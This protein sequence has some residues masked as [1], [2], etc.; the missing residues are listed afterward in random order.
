MARRGFSLKNSKL[1]TKLLVLV[2]HIIFQVLEMIRHKNG[3]LEHPT[4]GLYMIKVLE[5]SSKVQNRFLFKQYYS[6]IRDERIK[7]FPWQLFKK[8]NI[9]YKTTSSSWQV[10]IGAIVVAIE[11]SKIMMKL[12]NFLKRS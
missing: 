3:I 12:L 7:I 8:I 10:S 2:Y 1:I 5:N 6:L 4:L 9:L 11:M